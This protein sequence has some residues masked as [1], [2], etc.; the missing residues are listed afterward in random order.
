MC[1]RVGG[2]GDSVAEVARAFGVGW[3]TAMEAIRAHGAPLIDDP[4]RTATTAMG[5]DETV[6]LHANRSRHTAN[7]TGMVELD[8]ARLLDVVEGRSGKVLGD[9]LDSR[10][11]AWRD[12]TLLPMER[13]CETGNNE[14]EEEDRQD[15]L[16]A[17]SKG[18][19]L[20]LGGVEGLGPA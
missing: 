18:D 8:R 15:A 12:Q 13:D 10:S 17:A 5:V 1:R 4:A 16:S 14:G 19:D 9:W 3:H 2:D 11:Q 20:I 6:F 7:V